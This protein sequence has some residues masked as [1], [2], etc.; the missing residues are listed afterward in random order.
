MDQEAFEGLLLDSPRLRQLLAEQ[1][2][3]SEETAAIL[4][5]ALARQIDPARLHDDLLALQQQAAVEECS[6]IRD[7]LLNAMRSRLSPSA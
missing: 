1:Q 6:P 5:E 7:R 3:A 4:A 2:R